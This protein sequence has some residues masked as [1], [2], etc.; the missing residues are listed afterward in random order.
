VSYT[1]QTGG[2]PDCGRATTRGLRLRAG[3]RFDDWRQAGAEISR[4]S[5]ASAWWLG[6]WVVYG[7]QAYGSRY[8]AALEV[9]ALDYKTLRNYAW[10]ARR[11]ELSRRRDT[12]SF[13]H[14]AEVA[15]LGPAEQELWLARADRQRW[16]RNELRR[17]LAAD[18][19]RRSHDVLRHEL[20]LRMEIALAREQRWRDA[21]SSAEQDLSDWIARAA[22]EAADVALATAAALESDGASLQGRLAA[23]R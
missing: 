13:Q 14:H 16:S 20:V 10:V 17:H 5:S 1:H 19:A 6:D 12:L 9:T 11:F 23:S 2:L 18:R 15:G 7:E 21:A 22:D 4:I 3:L 8:R